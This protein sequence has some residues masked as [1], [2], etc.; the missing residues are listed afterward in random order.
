M[1]FSRPKFRSVGA[2]SETA[3]AEQHLRPVAGELALSGL[4]L[5]AITLVAIGLSGIL[6]FGLGLVEGRSFVSGS[7]VH[8]TYSAHTCR[9]LFEDAPH[10]RNC[11]EAA[12]K[13]HFWVVIWERIGAGALGGVLLAVAT[14]LRRRRRNA[15]TATLSDA[16]AASFATA[17]FAVVGIGLFARG[18]DIALRNAD[19]GGGGFL[20]VGVV[21]LALAAWF[22]VETTRALTKEPFAT[23]R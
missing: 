4:R 18:L 2:M 8:V 6:A 3:A 21:A 9:E 17:T 19:G 10:A 22:A 12:A 15:V 20:S 11:A 16:L 7:A 1:R 23:G 5:A 14:A 13:R